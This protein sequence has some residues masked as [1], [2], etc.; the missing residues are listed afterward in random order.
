MSEQSEHLSDLVSQV[1]AHMDVYI[2][3]NMP[4]KALKLLMVNRTHFKSSKTSTVA[5]YNLLLKA[6]VSSG[7]VEKA[8][9]IYRIMKTGSVKPNFETY[10]LMFEII[11]RIKNK[12]KR[13]GKWKLL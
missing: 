8:F 4:Q 11:G 6:H 2:Q 13:A 10:A 7:H 5:L 1:L 9:E 12:D 3:I